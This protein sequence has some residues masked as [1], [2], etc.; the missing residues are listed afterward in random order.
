MPWTGATPSCGQRH[1][2]R[3]RGSW[4]SERIA[5]RIAT[6]RA[7]RTDSGTSVLP[8]GRRQFRTGT[9]PRGA[10]FGHPTGGMVGRS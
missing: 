3:P 9:P 6:D 10:A 7:S 8:P 1:E 5:A 2:R 4:T